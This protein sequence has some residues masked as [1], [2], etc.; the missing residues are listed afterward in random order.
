MVQN[1]CSPGNVQCD[2]LCLK[3]LQVVTFIRAPY[4]S[5]AGSEA[6]EVAC[7]SEDKMTLFFP[8]ATCSSKMLLM[9]RLL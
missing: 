3:E 2:L 7:D 6:E 9:F 4:R 1:T 5:S 8:L